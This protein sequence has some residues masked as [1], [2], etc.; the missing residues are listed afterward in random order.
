MQENKYLFLLD[1]GHGG[2][3]DGVPQTEGKR[4]PKWKDGSQLF[5]GEFTRAIVDSLMKTSPLMKIEC[6]N[7]VPELEDISLRERVQRAS[8]FKDCYKDKKC[9]YVSIHANAGGGRG[10]E[11]FTSP[12][13]TEADSIAT[14]FVKKFAETFPM[15]RIRTDMTDGDPDKEAGFYVLKNTSMPAILT[16]CFFM[17]N[18][19][20]CKSYLMTREGRHNI[21]LAHLAAMV[22]IERGGL[23]E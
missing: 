20:E 22:E 4:S 21:A 14:V 19:H 10:Y 23:P 18:E 5:E 3:I 13:I 12:G 16:E 15:V 17:D 6:R 2:V 7:L 11:V 8:T 1:P 9:I